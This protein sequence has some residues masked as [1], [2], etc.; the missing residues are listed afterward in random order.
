MDKVKLKLR[1]RRL[2]AP[3]IPPGCPSG[4]YLFYREPLSVEFYPAQ[5]R[6][7]A[8]LVERFA[9]SVGELDAAISGPCPGL[10]IDLPIFPVPVVPHTLLTTPNTRVYTA[11]PPKV[12]GIERPNITLVRLPESAVISGNYEHVEIVTESAPLGYYESLQPA[13]ESYTKQRIKYFQILHER[14]VWDWSYTLIH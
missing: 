11:V 7:F 2:L 5:L 14:A 9:I 3:R 12:P 1:S 6:G 8:A 4:P 13:L 10:N